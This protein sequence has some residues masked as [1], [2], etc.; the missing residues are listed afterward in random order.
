[1]AKA[2]TAQ[3]QDT[4]FVQFWLDQLEGY[5]QEYKTWE[6]RSERIVKR[7]RDERQEKS[8]G[9]PDVNSKFNALWSNVQTLRD[10]KSVV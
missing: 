3:N 5:V 7:Y 6:K 10:R 8:D 2:T 1:M 4:A 9:S